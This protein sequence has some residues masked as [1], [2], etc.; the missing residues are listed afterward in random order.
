MAEAVAGGEPARQA[1]ELGDLLFQAVFLAQLLEEPGPF[2]L[3]A[4]A[5]GQAD[6]LVSRHPH[7][8]GD[9][10][11]RDAG[12]V[13]DLWERRKREERAGQGIFHDLPGGPARP[14]VR[15]Q[16][17]E[18]RRRRRLRLRRAVRRPGHPGR[19]GGRAAP[20]ARRLG[21]RRRAVRLRRRGPAARRR[22]RARPARLGAAVPRPR[23]AGGRAR[24][25]GR[26]ALRRA[27]RVGPARAGTSG[28]RPEGS[29]SR[30]G[31][32]RR[33]PDP[34]APMSAIVRVR[35]R[36]ILDSRG[37]PTVEAEVELASGAVGPRGGPL[38]R[39]HGHAGGHRAARRRHLG[40]R[41]QGGHEGRGQRRGRARR[42]AH[43]PGGGRPGRRRPHDDRAGRHPQQG[44]PGG[45]R[46][47]RLLAGG[48]PRGGVRGR[49]APLPLPGRGG[50]APPARAAHEHP[51][52]GRARR[53]HGRP[54][55]VHGRPGRRPHV[56]RRPA[57][58][59]R[60]LRRA[61][62]GAARA[63]A[64]HRGGRRGRL[65]PR[66][67]HQRRGAGDHHARH[68]GRRL[69]AGPGRGPRPG[70]GGQRVPP[71]RRV[72]PVRRGP[73]ARLGRHGRLLR[74]ALRA[75]PDRLDRGRHG[76]GRLG[77]L[78][79]ADRSPGR[80]D[81]ARRATTCS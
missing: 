81:P 18:A 73:H 79:G 34:G 25:R 5:R 16:G 41:R 65:R 74:R 10:E 50:R 9:A 52:R 44:P 1:D 38:G 51:Q 45:Q 23:R 35:A 71:G 56:R 30:P 63:R 66:P 14:R 48:G 53:Q 40:L 22:S 77:R 76:R 19:G 42:G 20:G 11:A 29:P 58:G 49:P 8:Y 2:D 54:P 33:P 43:R 80:P 68:R 70:S 57:H 31:R 59:R 46:D 3:A 69:H 60:G 72:R 13:V 28:P 15:D 64:V 75:V 27:A 61:Q 36:Q 39:E 21:A 32:L 6:K 47:P 26:G 12:R 4:V 78:A 17:A 7:V 62:A 67:G 37:Q 24:R 55:G